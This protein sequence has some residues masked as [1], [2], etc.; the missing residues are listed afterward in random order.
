MVKAG[1]TSLCFDADFLPFGCE[2]DVT[3]TCSVNNYKFEGKERDTETGNDNFGARHYS[4][5]FARW[6]SECRQTRTRWP[7]IAS[8]RSIKDPDR[9]RD[10]LRRLR[11][12]HKKHAMSV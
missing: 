3:T 10:I 4:S 1:A 7:A 2:K 11:T 12:G 8:S 9:P 5:D 6:L